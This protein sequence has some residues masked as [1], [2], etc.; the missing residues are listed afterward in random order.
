MSATLF[1]DSVADSFKKSKKIDRVIVPGGCTLKYIQAPNLS[2]N[3]P[4]KSLCTEK[5]DG[6]LGT[7]EIYDETEFQSTPEKNYFAMDSGSLSRV[8]HRCYQETFHMLC[9]EPFR[10]QVKRRFNSLLQKGTAL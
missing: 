9:V 4:F 3:K 10:G 1:K 7:V 2:S 5:Q 8:T 6:W